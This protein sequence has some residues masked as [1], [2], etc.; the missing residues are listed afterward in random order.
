MIE[1][2]SRSAEKA[3]AFAALQKLSMECAEDD[4]D[5][6]GAKRL[7]PT[8]IQTAIDFIHALPDTIPL[9]EFAPEP[10]G[11]LSLD[12]IASQTRLFSVSIDGS[13]RLAYAWLEGDDK[14]HGVAHFNRTTIPR[15]VLE[16]ISATVSYA[17]VGA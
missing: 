5:G 12:W 6:H 3:A 15:R 9:P 1:T 17:P 11:A 14:G 8:V 4:W 10:D 13:N 7:K 2:V 16:G